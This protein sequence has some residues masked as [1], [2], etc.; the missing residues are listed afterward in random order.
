[1]ELHHSVWVRGNPE[2]GVV[3]CR[4][5]LLVVINGKETVGSGRRGRLECDI[6]HLSEDDCRLL[7]NDVQRYHRLQYSVSE[8][9]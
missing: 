4:T 3:S 1:M 8:L 2:G 7:A 5:K 9:Y 6:S